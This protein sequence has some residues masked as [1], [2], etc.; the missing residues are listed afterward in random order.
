MSN[1]DTNR[2]MNVFLSFFFECVR[3]NHMNVVLIFQLFLNYYL[4]LSPV[5][6]RNKWIHFYIM[7]ALFKAF[8]LWLFSLLLAQDAGLD[9]LAVVISR[10]KI[11]GQEIGN[12]LEEQN[13]K[14]NVPLPRFYAFF[15]LP[16]SQNIT[17]QC[18]KSK[19]QMLLLNGTTCFINP[20]GKEFPLASP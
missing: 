3:A 9:A 16:Y 20:D 13:G 15:F 5:T 7:L 1:L 10:Q 18:L 6:A 12:E 8:C 4:F 11:M 19:R 17:Y 2:S 14:F